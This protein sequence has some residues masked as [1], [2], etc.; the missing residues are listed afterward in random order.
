MSTQAPAFQATSVNPHGLTNLIRNL[1]RDCTPSQYLREFTKNSIEACQRTGKPDA[2]IVLD[3]NPQ[4]LEDFGVFKLSITDNGDGMSVEQMLNLLNNLSA[5]GAKQNE[6]QNYGVGAKISAMTRNHSGILYESWKN[7]EGHSV[8]ICYNEQEDVYGIQGFV[9]AQG[10]TVYAKPVPNE[11]KPAV[12]KDHGTR[13][14]LLG[15]HFTQDTMLPPHG[16]DNDRDNWIINYLNTRFYTLPAGIKIIARVG[17]FLDN[18]AAPPSNIENPPKSKLVEVLGFKSRI[19][20]VAIDSGEL[21]LSEPQPAKSFWWILPELSDIVGQTGLINQGEVFDIQ[22]DR[23]N[24]SLYF[25]IIVGRNRVV[26][27]VEPLDAV[28]NTARTGLVKP[29]GSH[30]QW[31]T[32]QDEFRNNMPE[33]LRAFIEQLLQQSVLATNSKAILNRLA[34]LKDFYDFNGYQ[35]IR[36][37]FEGEEETLESTQEPDTPHEDE[38]LDNEHKDE[39]KEENAD[40]PKD[41]KE[42]TENTDKS[43]DAKLVENLFPFVEWTSEDKSPQLAGK[44]AEFIELEN[45]IIVNQDFKG[46]VDLN[47]YFKRRFGDSTEIALLIKLTVAEGI[48]QILM[49][50]VAGILSLKSQDNWNQ[51]QINACLTKEAL[52]TAVM[53]RYWLVKQVETELMLKIK[54]VQKSMAQH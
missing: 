31:N 48:E 5:S 44:A 33:G 39:G 1:G 51:G 25:G 42:N 50:C 49:E 40:E 54:D 36:P 10:Q 22:N 11:N 7:G 23:T 43:K 13:V 28:Q 47:N 53:Q 9:S 35:P 17:Y 46:F 4:Y 18:P 15:M 3:Y 19:E 34:S 20:A 21:E 45:A 29:D 30:L 37:D 41:E 38:H 2:Q 12:I 6:H 26:I 8:L 52:T 27:Y 14:T 16:V 24:R 32:W